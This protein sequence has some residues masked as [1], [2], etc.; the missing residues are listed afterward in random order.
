MLYITIIL[1]IIGRITC[2]QTLAYTTNDTVYI[3]Y[4]ENIILSSFMSTRANESISGSEVKM[5]I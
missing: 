4:A 3:P 1:G 5:L 2:G